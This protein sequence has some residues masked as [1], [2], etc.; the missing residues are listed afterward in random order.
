MGVLVPSGNTTMEPEL[1]RIAPRGVSLHFARLKLAADTRE[2]IERMSDDL[3]EQAKRLADGNVNVICFG[4]TGG[5][6]FG[7]VGYDKKIIKRIEDVTGRT[8]TTTST[9]VI[10]ALKRLNA[11]NLAVASPYPEWLNRRLRDFLEGQDFHVVTLK[12]L[13]LE[14]GMEDVSP[15]EILRL[16]KEVAIHEADAVFISC[17][18]FRALEIVDRLEQDLGK[19]V[20]S[21]NQATLWMLLR[22]A[23]LPDTLH[24]YGELLRIK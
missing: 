10:E 11:K 9:A 20:V 6:L 12:G 13:G 7:G 22:L 23:H 4:C 5:S 15:E 19:P 14:T 24:G 17:T 8:A 18:D 21:S 1:Y 2:E 3:E 16:A